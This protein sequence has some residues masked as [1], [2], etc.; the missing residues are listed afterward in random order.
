MNMNATT[1]TDS[2]I[3]GI[4]FDKRGFQRARWERK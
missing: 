3:V 1:A 2:D 4:N